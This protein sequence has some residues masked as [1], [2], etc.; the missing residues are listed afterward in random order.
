ME[1]GSKIKSDV[2]NDPHAMRAAIQCLEE[3]QETVFKEYHETEARNKAEDDARPA[4]SVS[5]GKLEC[6]RGATAVLG[7]VTCVN[8]TGLLW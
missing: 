7:G 4:C 6:K 1:S 2:A 5:D 3:R 8:T